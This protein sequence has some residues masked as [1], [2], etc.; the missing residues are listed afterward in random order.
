MPQPLSSFLLSF[1]L[2]SAYAASAQTLTRAA[3]LN[4]GYTG[5]SLNI[6]A[7]GSMVYL[8]DFGSRQLRIYDASTPSAPVFKAATAAN[9]ARSV[10]VSGTKAY[11][12]G[13]ISDPYPYPGT[14]QLVDVSVPTA[15]VTGRLITISAPSF[16]MAANS[17]L[18]CLVTNT[19]QLQVF[20]PTLNQL[21]TLACPADNITLNGTVAYAQSGSQCYVYDL[22]TPSQPRLHA[23]LTGAIGAVSGKLAAGVLAATATAGTVY[24]Y[25]VSDPL[26]PVLLSSIANNGGTQLAMSSTTVYTTG[27]Y[28]FVVSSPSTLQAFSISTPTAP[29]LL[30]T[31][32]ARSNSLGLAANGPNVYLL[33]GALEIYTL[34]GG[35]V[36]ATHAATPVGFTLSPNPARGTLTLGQAP[37]NVPVTIYDLTG[38][39]CLATPALPLTGTLD[40]AS[41][42]PGLYQ[43][44]VG[45]AV[46]KLVVE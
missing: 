33:N 34:T 23:T 42:S 3:S 36:T 12:R 44:R 27:L 26:N 32:A 38:R 14:L 29:V 25:N 41:L 39:V 46:R 45:D 7:N 30:A 19:G 20:D 35:I 4:D 17:S 11:V 21:G 18:V 15:P 31:V 22:S 16:S 28:A 10:V 2:L 43:V 1:A 37:A 40:I 13:Q 5:T 6:A 9:Q 8:A 24:I